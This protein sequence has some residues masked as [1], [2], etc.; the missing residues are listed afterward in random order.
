MPDNVTQI[1]LD[2]LRAMRED[3]APRLRKVES[4]QDNADGK[5]TMFGL[6]CSAIGGI[7]VWFVGTFK[8]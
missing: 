5:I 4:W 8:H 2:E 7:V 3:I 6:F 1:I